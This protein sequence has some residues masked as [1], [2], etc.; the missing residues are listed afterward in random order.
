[1]NAAAR[2]SLVRPGGEENSKEI[3]ELRGDWLTR[4]GCRNAFA[5]PRR[6]LYV[7]TVPAR[8]E[9]R[10]PTNRGEGKRLR[11]PLPGRREP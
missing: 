11:E 5:L 7:H 2:R 8:E 9:V 10:I 1:M 6:I 3:R 4:P